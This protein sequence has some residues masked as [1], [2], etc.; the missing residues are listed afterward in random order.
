MGHEAGLVDFA[1][2]PTAQWWGRK[3]A[4]LAD[5]GVHVFKVDG[6]DSHETPAYLNS[7]T[8]RSMA[9]LHN[10]YPVLFAKSVYEGIQRSDQRT[11][12]WIRT[13]FSGIQ[14]YPCC[15]GGDQKADFSGGRVLIKAG[16]Q[17][18]LAGISFWSHDV[19]GFGGTPTEEYYIRSFQ[20]GLLSPL[21]RAHG[22]ITAPWNMGERACRIAARF[23][24]LRYRLLPLIYSYAWHSHL[25]GE[26]MMR[27]MVL[28][29]QDDPH[30]RQAEFQYKLGPDLLIAPIYRESNREDLTATRSLYLPEGT[31]WNF[32]TDQC[33]T[34]RQ[35]LTVEAPI[36]TLPLYVRGGA[37]LMYGEPVRRASQP[38]NR[39]ELHLYAGGNGTLV[40]YEDDGR[41]QAYRTGERAVTSFHLGDTGGGLSLNI[42]PTNGTF[43]GQSA[44]LNLTLVVHGI[45]NARSATVNGQSITVRPIDGKPALSLIH[46]RNT[47][48]QITIR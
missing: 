21:S 14:Q 45:P 30:A 7:V 23:I 31:W 33:H 44:E 40:Y 17:S 6:G 24:R 19:G 35:T 29:Y 42:S 38:Q 25:T 3:A 48:L 47:T 43:N 18:G 34:G 15:W 26:P 32:W 39:L 20:W 8:G 4:K 10:L 2:D 1:D 5:D 9:E 36:D 46:P 37:I 28:D 13:G 22:S 16:Q 41:T 11:L 12:T 27:A